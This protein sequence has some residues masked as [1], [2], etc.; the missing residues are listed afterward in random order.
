MNPVMSRSDLADLVRGA[1]I[2]GIAFAIVCLFWGLGCLCRDIAQWRV[3]GW[4]RQRLINLSGHVKNLSTTQ[5]LLLVLIALA[6]V[7]VATDIY[8]RI[9]QA[10]T[11]HAMTCARFKLGPNCIIN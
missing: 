2:I 6:A 3:W 8:L 7:W 5:V 4:A 11:E 1:V 9:G 10:R